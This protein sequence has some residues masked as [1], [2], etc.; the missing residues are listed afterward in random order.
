MADRSTSEQGPA[1]VGVVARAVDGD[2][3]VLESAELNEGE[4]VTLFHTECGT[5]VVIGDV[6]EDDV[7]ELETLFR[8]QHWA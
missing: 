5:V 6:G 8:D 2:F 1:I 3:E 7:D 4:S